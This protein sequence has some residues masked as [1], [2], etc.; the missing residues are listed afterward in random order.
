M[1]LQ[2][3]CREI[4]GNRECERTLNDRRFGCTGRQKNGCTGFENMPYADGNAACERGGLAEILLTNFNGDRVEVG[5]VGVGIPGGAGLIERQVTI[6][7][8]T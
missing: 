4:P 3:G 7:A 2:D 5:N 6:H 1:V 8:D